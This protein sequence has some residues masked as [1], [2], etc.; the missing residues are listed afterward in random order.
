MQSVI[1]WR[2]VPI[3][4]NGTIG[5]KAKQWYRSN[6]QPFANVSTLYVNDLSVLRLLSGF[7]MTA[8]PKG[9]REKVISAR[10]LN[11]L[12]SSWKFSVKSVNWQVTYFVLLV[13]LTFGFLLLL[14]KT[15][16]VV[17][18]RGGMFRVY[19]NK[20]MAPVEI[21]SFGKLSGC[22]PLMM[23]ETV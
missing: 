4:L 23:Q 20:G 16:F 3:T 15:A 7:K 14:F 2:I 13:Y 11:G 18:R 6:E 22:G 9:I 8:C 10:R 17:V 12:G 1:P 21:V 5:L 19:T